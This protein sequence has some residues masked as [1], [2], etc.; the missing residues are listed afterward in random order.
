M[1]ILTLTPF[2]PTVRDGSQGSFV[3]EPLTALS[4][5]GVEGHVLCAQPFYRGAE[6]P[7]KTLSEFDS[8][9]SKTI[10]LAVRARHAE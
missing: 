9:V 10:N 4:T 1:N 3:S 2:F 5:I 7:A 8:S 6:G